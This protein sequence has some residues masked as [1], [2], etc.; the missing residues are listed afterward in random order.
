MAKQSNNKIK[1]PWAD[2]ADKSAALDKGG[3]ELIYNADGTI[4]IQFGTA[5]GS[6]VSEISAQ[7]GHAT[8]RA[9]YRFSP[10][11]N[12]FFNGGG[13]AG[14]AFTLPVEGVTLSDGSN[15]TIICIRNNFPSALTCTPNTGSNLIAIT[16]ATLTFTTNNM[17]AIYQQ[18]LNAGATL[19]DP[20]KLTT[21]QITGGITI[22]DI[23]EDFDYAY[24]TLVLEYYG[25]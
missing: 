7:S 6:S 16:S 14:A 9:V 4:T 5:D 17:I 1:L 24:F 25:A 3:I 19:T 10:Y 20:V 22:R 21:V 18:E 8:Y 2:A 13:G 11:D 15:G 23:P 12:D